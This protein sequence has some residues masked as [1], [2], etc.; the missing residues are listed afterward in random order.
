MR[1]PDQ[2]NWNNLVKLIQHVFV[3]GEIPQRLAFSTLVL[4]PEPDGG[5][6]GIGLLETIWKIIAIIIKDRLVDTSEFDDSLHGFLPRRGT[7]TAI[8]EAKL[9]LDTTIATG[10]TIYQVFMDLSK[11]YDS[12]SREKLLSLL[13]QYRVGP[14]L[15][16]IL[17]NFW[18]QLK[19]APKQGGFYGKPIQTARGVT[20]GDPLSPI[21]FNIVVDAVIR[22]TKRI[23]GPINS[24]NIFYAD[25]GL[26]TGNT[27]QDIQQYLN[28]I[29]ELF[30]R[31]GLR[32]NANKTKVLVGRPEINN[33]RICSPVFNRRFGGSDPSY[34]EYKKQPVE[35]PICKLVLQRVSL[36]RHMINQH[37]VY[38][39]PTTRNSVT[40]YFQQQPE[41]YQILMDDNNYVDCP[42]PT[43]P[44][45]Y[46]KRYSMRLHFQHRHWM[47]TLIINE[48]QAMI[49]CQNCFLYCRNPNSQK[50]MNSN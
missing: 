45:T 35:C 33:H 8:I 26:I 49:K 3:T 21:L 42:V 27:L 31:I 34:A 25:D 38:E 19:V 46:A 22:E 44:G 40:P 7:A 1:S 24:N 48:E 50:H 16:S 17:T 2:T 5:V 30:S 29:T 6:R 37:D 12:V 9:K 43:C 15:I 11:A 47:D 28:I 14:H 23:Q 32:T 36:P 20:Q 4:L 10:T 13:S 39:L 18:T 41:T